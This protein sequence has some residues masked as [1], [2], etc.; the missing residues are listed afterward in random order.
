MKA[1][2]FGEND[3]GGP[4]RSAMLFSKFAIKLRKLIRISMGLRRGISGDCFVMES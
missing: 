1:P 3:G 2:S 4:V